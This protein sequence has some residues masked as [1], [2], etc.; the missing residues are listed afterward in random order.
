MRT[1]DI[2]RTHRYVSFKVL[3]VLLSIGRRLVVI[4]LLN[5]LGGRPIF[6]RRI[7]VQESVI[8][9]G[10]VLHV[11]DCAGVVTTEYVGP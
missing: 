10:L 1:L 8:E 6:D 4:M 9:C 7:I 5:L 11:N 2:F 3:H